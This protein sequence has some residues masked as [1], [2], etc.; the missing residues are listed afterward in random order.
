MRVTSGSYYNNIYGENN[1]LNK[2]LF[3]VN[4]QIASGLK[5]QYAHED[6]NIFIDTLRLD[7]E[8]TTLSQVKNSA[9]SAYKMSTQTDTTI[10]AIV[11]TLESMKVKMVNAA[12][13][14]HS[15]TS[16]QAIA[17]ELRG[18]QNHLLTLANTSI[19]GQYLFSGT[20]TSVKPIGTDGTY[21]GNDKNLEAFLGSG[22]KQKYNISGS[23]LFLGDESKINRTISANVP[24]MSLNNL[25][26]DIMQ[27]STLS[28]DNSQEIYITAESTIRDL[29]GDTDADATTSFTPHFYIQGTKSNGTTFKTHIDSLSMNASVDDLLTAIK[30]EYGSTQVNVSLN[31]HGQIEIVDKQAGSSKLDFHMVGAVDFDNT[32]AGDTADILDSIYGANVGNIDNLQLGTI[33]FETAAITTPGL[34]IK[35]FTKSGFDTPSSVSNTIEGINYDRTNFAQNGAKLLSSI[36][37]IDKTTNNYATSKS[38]LVDIA[39][40]STLDAQQLIIEGVDISGAA[41]TAQIDFAT[42]GSTFSLDGGTTNFSIFNTNSTSRSAV[43]ADEMTYQQLLDV[44]N[45]AMSGNLPSANTDIAYDAAITASNIQSSTTLDYAGKV[46]FE[47]KNN[48]I[49]G[50][51]LSIY[52]TNSADYSVTIGSALTFN[53]N[54]AISKRDPKTDFFTEI[55]ET[56]RSVEQGKKYSDGTN[57]NDPRNLGIQNAIQKMDDLSDHVSRL[58]T[59]VGSYS[60]VLQASTDR[61]DMLLISTKTLQSDVIDTDIAES[62]LK[63]QQLSL[64]YQALLSNIS[65]VSK[66]SLVNYL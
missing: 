31:A 28:R 21:Q 50:A 47:D 39:G 22:I 60:Q 2:Q 23:Q 44:V 36:S 3:D 57:S 58:Q 16:I 41:F 4:K 61:T 19:G 11:K 7:D 20:A 45:M 40:V 9:Q 13:D 25:Y 1:K 14:A 35:E 62:Q 64:N 24:Q 10:G 63:L 38:K 55:E 32:N 29:M 53:A 30:N 34:Y 15:D 65:K 46:V 37:Q 12:N 54:S 5:I 59:E 18:L 66:L 48:P 26:P 43:D 49:T 6:P 52:D 27:D 51:S 8:I 17:K 56:I 33:D 42:A